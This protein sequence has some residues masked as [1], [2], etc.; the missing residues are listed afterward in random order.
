M[1]R[2]SVARGSYRAPSKKAPQRG[3]ADTLL[4]L[5]LL[6]ITKS[7]NA[8]SA[9]AGKWLL[10]TLWAGKSVLSLSAWLRRLVLRLVGWIWQPA[11]SERHIIQRW[12]RTWGVAAVR[13]FHIVLGEGMRGARSVGLRGGGQGR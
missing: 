13:R 9:V 4:W 6:T 12:A 3:A 1:G 11:T 8:V 10:S 2:K 5:I 7:I